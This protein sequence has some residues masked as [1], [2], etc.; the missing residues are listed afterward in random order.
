MD[1]D[2]YILTSRVGLTRNWTAP[3]TPGGFPDGLTFTPVSP[4]TGT[5]TVTAA[6]ATA[7]Q[8]ITFGNDNRDEFYEN[9]SGSDG[10]GAIAA[11][12]TTSFTGGAGPT[13]A[14][15]PF[16]VNGS[17]LYVNVGT[18]A[19]PQWRKTDLDNLS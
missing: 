14:N 15:A 10:S 7:A 17:T 18:I 11:V 5:P 9:G 4:A 16:L 19:E 12:T 2:T 6:A 8:V 1:P 13:T 3:Y